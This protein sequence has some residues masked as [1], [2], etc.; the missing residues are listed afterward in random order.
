MAIEIAISVSNEK[1]NRK[2]R[3][4]FNHKNA[5]KTIPNENLPLNAYFVVV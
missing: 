5:A 4:I 3:R 2:K 1:L